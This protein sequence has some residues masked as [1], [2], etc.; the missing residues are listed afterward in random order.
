[1][2]LDPL[3]LRRGSSGLARR[4]CRWTGEQCRV[5]GGTASKEATGVCEF[6]AGQT[7]SRVATV[8][9]QRVV[10]DK[11]LLNKV[12]RDVCG[13]EACN[14]SLHGDEVSHQTRQDLPPPP[15]SKRCHAWIYC[16]TESAPSRWMFQSTT[17]FLAGR[18]GGRAIGM[19]NVVS[20]RIYVGMLARRARCGA[21]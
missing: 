1:M 15:S 19:I 18:I 12:C 6:G 21:G 16:Q 13:V 9:D 5:P 3:L 8:A 20:C 7:W 11:L 17:T 4:D 14:E 10:R 2:R